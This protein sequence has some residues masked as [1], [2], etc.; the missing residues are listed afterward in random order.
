MLIATL[1]AL[2][3]LAPQGVDTTV[4]QVERGDRLEAENH[5]GNITV[6]SWDRNA[7]M[8]R[9]NGSRRGV[10]IERSAGEVRVELDWEGGNPGNVDYEITAPAW[11]ALELSGLHSNITVTGSKAAISASTVSGTIDVDGGSGNI[12]LESVEGRVSLSNAT[13]RFE[14]SA[15]NSGIV[16]RN[17]TGPISAESVNG[18]VTISR[19]ES[20]DVDA[21]TVN[22]D[23]TFGGP[24]QTG[25][26]Y[27][28]STHNGNVTVGIQEGAS[29]IVSISTFQG[30]VV[31]DFP[32][33]YRSSRERSFSFTM[34]G[35]S[36][37]LDIESFQGTIR[38]ARPAAVSR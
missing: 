25:G 28:L 29:A 17:V 8:V 16:V 9:L 27:S 22:G 38:L 32:L 14:L 7:V 23:I 19:A 21:S 4:I 20:S 30:E 36:A 18:G 24:I 31:A 2:T 5:L 15:V 12:E 3:L 6:R 26:R 10:E 37:R 35:G 11:M 1:A 33:S 13:G 34:G